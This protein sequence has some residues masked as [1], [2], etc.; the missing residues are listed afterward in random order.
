MSSPTA[1]ARNTPN[2]RARAEQPLADD[3]VEQRLRVREEAASPPGPTV[4]SV[5]MAG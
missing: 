5:R 4:G 1:L 2:T 3:P